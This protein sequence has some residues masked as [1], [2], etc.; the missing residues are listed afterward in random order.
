MTNVFLGKVQSLGLPVGETNRVQTNL[1]P[2]CRASFLFIGHAVLY[3]V[4]K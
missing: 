1:E 3:A 4:L 2:F